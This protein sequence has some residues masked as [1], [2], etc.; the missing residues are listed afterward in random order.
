MQAQIMPGQQ[1]Q[2]PKPVR[3]IFVDGDLDNWTRICGDFSP[4]LSDEKLRAYFSDFRKQNDSPEFHTN[5]RPS[6]VVNKLVE[7]GWRIKGDLIIF[8][9]PIK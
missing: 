2:N 4:Y 7:L 3:H 6:R 8:Y 1:Q 9:S 5:Y